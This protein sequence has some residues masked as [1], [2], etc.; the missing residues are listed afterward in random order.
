M[1][2]G[3]TGRGGSRRRT[4]WSSCPGSRNRSAAA[5][6]RPSGACASGSRTARGRVRPTP[7]EP[8]YEGRDEP[9]GQQQVGEP[10]PERE[11]EVDPRDADRDVDRGCEAVTAE[12]G[13]IA[14]GR[15]VEAQ[16]QAHG[17]LPGA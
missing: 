4:T 17:R 2:S 13:E 9:R 6:T 7:G 16:A 12:D 1:P 3:P 11:Q 14:A 15:T 10:D 8:S 5:R